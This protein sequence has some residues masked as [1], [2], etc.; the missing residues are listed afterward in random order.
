MQ[1]SEGHLPGA[2]VKV[3]CAATCCTNKLLLL[4]SYAKCPASGR[5]KVAQ[6]YIAERLRRL[7]ANLLLCVQALC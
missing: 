4:I 5:K 3:I 7:A 2:G 1:S 6:C